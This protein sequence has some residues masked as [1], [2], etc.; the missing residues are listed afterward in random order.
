MAEQGKTLQKSAISRRT[1][2]QRMGKI[3]GGNKIHLNR[4]LDQHRPFTFRLQ[5]TGDFGYL[6]L[7]TKFSF[8]K[9]MS[10]G[11]QQGEAEGT[12]WGLE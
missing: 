12:V 11:S 3:Q 10:I 6:V 9:K 5:Q 2:D 8:T 1:E 7:Y 4:I